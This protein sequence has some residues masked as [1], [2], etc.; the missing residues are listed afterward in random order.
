MASETL[1]ST[2]W[3]MRGGPS[4][5]IWI[6]PINIKPEVIHPVHILA[7]ESPPWFFVDKPGEAPPSRKHGTR[8]K[9]LEA[10]AR[11]VR[12]WFSGREGKQHQV[13]SRGELK[14]SRSNC[15]RAARYRSPWAGR[16]TSWGSPP[17]GTRRGPRSTKPPIARGRTNK[18][19]YLSRN[20]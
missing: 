5:V 12:R 2:T 14:K 8:G 20:A 6:P 11:F 10:K 19:S 17:T 18:G 3:I 13:K 7:E 15:I 9:Y 1:H 16:R 4:K